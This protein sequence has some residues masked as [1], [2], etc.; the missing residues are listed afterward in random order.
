M[1]REATRRPTFNVAVMYDGL[2]EGDSRFYYI[3]DKVTFLA[4]GEVNTGDGNTLVEFV[5]WARDQFPC[6]HSALIIADH[7]N[8]DGTAYDASSSTFF[9]KDYLTMPDLKSAYGQIVAHGG[10]VDVLVMDACLMGTIESAYQARG[11]ADYYVASEQIAW[12]PTEPYY[13]NQIALDSTA[14]SV[15]RAIALSYEKNCETWKVP[16]TI[17]VARLS[18]LPDLA[19]KVSILGGLVKDKMSILHPLMLPMAL[20]VQ[21][22]DSNWPKGIGLSDEAIDLYDFACL[23]RGMRDDEQLQTAAKAVMDAIQDDPVA[24]NRYIIYEGHRSG[25][26]PAHIDPETPYWNLVHSHGV[27]AFFPSRSRSFYNEENF[28]FAAGTDWSRVLQ[29]DTVAGQ[30]AETIEWGPM[31]VEYVRFTN[32]NEPDDPNPAPLLAPVSTWRVV[33]LPLILRN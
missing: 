24:S 28:D 5:N 16:Y 19:Q 14:E 9:F 29:A 21:R 8:L 7:G 17:S 10:K 22:F 13:L 18:R 20:A 15:A 25:N 11:F 31:L 1:L 2:G 4:K 33:Y 12:G 3:A 27:S 26:V 6:P 23:V 30:A 32:P